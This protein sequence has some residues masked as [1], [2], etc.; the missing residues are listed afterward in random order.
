[1]FRYL[2][3]APIA[4]PAGWVVGDDYMR[5]WWWSRLEPSTRLKLKDGTDATTLDAWINISTKSAD[6]ARQASASTK[7]ECYGY[8][9]FENPESRLIVNVGLP[10]E[11]FEPIL[12]AVQAGKPPVLAAGFGKP[13]AF[14]KLTGSVTT[15]PNEPLTYGWNS[16]EPIEV[17]TFE[18][19]YSKDTSSH[20]L[21]EAP[22]RTPAVLRSLGIAWAVIATL[23]ALAIAIAMYQITNSK[24]EVAVVSVLLLIYV[25]GVAMAMGLQRTLGAVDLQGLV[26]HISLRELAGVSCSSEERKA[27]QSMHDRLQS[28]GPKFWIATVG[29]SII[30]LLAI[31]KLIGEL[32]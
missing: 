9:E 3:F 5:A 17:A 11:Q 23:I 12:S 32:L 8:V 18:I 2:R 7:T 14:A 15:S 1:M 16:D 25:N 13:E 6:A 19:S 24:F 20:V 28:P 26:R 27:I 10:K 30:G 31:Y 21:P 4:K 29:N 22:V